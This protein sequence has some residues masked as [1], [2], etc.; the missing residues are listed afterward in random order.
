[1]RITKSLLRGIRTRL[2]QRVKD[3]F[4][5]SDEDVVKLLKSMWTNVVPEDREENIKIIIL[6]SIQEFIPDSLTL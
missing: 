5:L 1:M 2:D 3:V 4:K 6:L